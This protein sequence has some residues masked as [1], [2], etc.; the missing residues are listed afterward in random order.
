MGKNNESDGEKQ[1]ELTFAMSDGE[2]ASFSFPASTSTNVM[3]DKAS[4]T[5]SGMD[6]QELVPVYYEKYQE[7]LEYLK[8]PVEYGGGVSLELPKID[9]VAGTIGGGKFEIKGKYIEKEP[10]KVKRMVE[11]IILK[12]KD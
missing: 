2:L 4:I 3:L 11:K 6:F 9:P 8:E 10:Q 1:L 7:T 5:I 12:R